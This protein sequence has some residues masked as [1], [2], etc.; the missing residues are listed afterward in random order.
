MAKSPSSETSSQSVAVIIPCYRETSHILSVIEKIG[1]EVAAIY[2]VDDA[3][4]DLTG[5]YVRDNCI[6][7]RACVIMQDVNSGVGGAMVTGYLRALKEGHDIL[8][9]IDGDGQMNPELILKLIAPILEKQV[10][11]AKGN[12]FHEI[13]SVMMMPKLRIFG[14]VCLSFLS[15]LSS[16]YW[17]VFDPTNGF[18]ALHRTAAERLSF[19]SIAKGYFFESDMLFRLG[20]IRAVVKDIPMEAFYGSEE[21]GISIPKVIP[22]FIAKHLLNAC[23]RIYFNYFLRD[24]G[25]TSFQFMLGN[26]LLWFGIIF[27]ITQWYESELSGIPATAGTVILAALPIILGSQFIISFFNSD[28]KSVPTISLQLKDGSND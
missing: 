3:C 24:F 17:S 20:I 15:K 26:I 5:A 9:K 28:I 7:N 16:G 13:D 1:P 12:R 18:T 11:Y 8:V 6:D 22:E 19:E 2:V 23:K 14:N 25:L 21:S 27:G 4:P 10:D